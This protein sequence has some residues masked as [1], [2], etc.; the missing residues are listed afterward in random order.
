MTSVS[1]RLKHKETAFDVIG[2]AEEILW[3]VKE[4]VAAEIGID[5][6][7]QKWIYK[8]RVLTNEQTVGDA[9]IANED[10]IRPCK[11][12]VFQYST[13]ICINNYFVD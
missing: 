12:I 2:E 10:T 8:G 4:R 1:F 13:S 6:A 7:F 11:A 5:G 9:G 3:N